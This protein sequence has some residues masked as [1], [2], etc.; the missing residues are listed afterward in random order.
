[1]IK[2]KPNSNKAS[3]AKKPNKIKKKA[4]SNSNKDNMDNP[5]SAW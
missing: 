2:K 4:R 1:M 3:N 5:K